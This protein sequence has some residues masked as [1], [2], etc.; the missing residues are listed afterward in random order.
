[1]N[2]LTQLGW[3]DDLT[4]AWNELSLAGSTPARVIADFGSVLKIALPEERKAEISGR[5]EYISEPTELPKVGDWVVVQLMGDDS[6]MVEAVLPRSSAITRKAAGDKVEKQILAVNIDVAFIVQALDH[7]FSPER[8]ERY[9]YQLKVSNIQ[10][11]LILNKADKTDNIAQYTDKLSSRVP[12]VTASAKTGEG[13]EAI[14]QHIKPGQT[15]VLLGSSG[16]G[17][18][19]IINQLLGQ[20]IQRTQEIREEDSMGRHTTT[21]RE[22]FRLENGGLLIDTPGIRE[23][24]LWGSE[25]ELKDTFEDVLQLM[26]LCQF[27][28][29]GHTT[30]PG[31]AVQA[32]IT[33]GK[34]SK[35]RYNNY[36]KMKK[37]L[38][39]LKTKA[40]QDT[41][42]EKKKARSK[43]LKQHYKSINES[44]RRKNK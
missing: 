15:A 36:L 9:L 13:M 7:D 38:G 14:L 19:T 18:S 23:L 3:N 43:I 44:P 29:C 30:E 35:T 4:R 5:L 37:E 25:E 1:M 21:H 42:A 8:I 20:E 39:Y 32:A 40:D 24:Q 11:V 22:L 27:S 33:A 16:V 26:P 34:L 2:D 12:Y 41:L 10:P 28:N 31:C 17:K 6:A